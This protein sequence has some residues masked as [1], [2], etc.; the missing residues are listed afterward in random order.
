MRVGTLGLRAVTDGEPR[1]FWDLF[2]GL[3]LCDRR[4]STAIV[5]LANTGLE[6]TKPILAGLRGNRKARG[7]AQDG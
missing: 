4:E 2:S 7:R 5:Q 3:E 1:R 6:Q